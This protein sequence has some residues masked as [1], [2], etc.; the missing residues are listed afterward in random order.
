ML[1]PIRGR[2]VLESWTHLA[3]SDVVVIVSDVRPHL[4]WV[5]GSVLDDVNH[6]RLP[7]GGPQELGE[8]HALRF[9]PRCFSRGMKSIDADILVA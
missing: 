6:E 9:F 3:L 5:E 7:F 4:G 1:C 2:E 8:K